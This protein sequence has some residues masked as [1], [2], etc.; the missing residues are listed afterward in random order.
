M[1]ARESSWRPV[2]R[3]H[4]RR[5]LLANP[6]ADA[7]TLRKAFRKEYPSVGYGHGWPYRVW[8]DEI[9]RM[10]RELSRFKNW[11]KRSGAFDDPVIEWLKG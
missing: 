3:P 11:Q 10:Q 6:G 2:V 4:I 5:V 9:V 7:K 1:A 8:L